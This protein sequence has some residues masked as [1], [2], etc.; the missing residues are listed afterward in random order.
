MDQTKQAG[1]DAPP[2]ARKAPQQ[3]GHGRLV[4]EYRTPDGNDTGK[5]ICKECGTIFEPG[6]PDREKSRAV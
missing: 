2:K 4:D 6:S 1:N 3:C 5:L